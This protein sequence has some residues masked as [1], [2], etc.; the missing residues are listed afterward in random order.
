[1]L[2][3]HLRPAG[4]QIVGLASALSLEC[5]TVYLGEG[6]LSYAVNATVV[7]TFPSGEQ[8]FEL[9]CRHIVGF[10]LPPEL[11]LGDEELAAYGQVTT[12]PLVLP[13]LRS[14][15]SDLT[16]RAGLPPLVLDTV[17]IPLPGRPTPLEPLEQ[18][19]TQPPALA[20]APS[21]ADIGEGSV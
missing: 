17:R 19:T 20:E 3:W 15:V 6:S 13:Y 7:A 4:A 14:L 5:E 12:I 18:G 10:A 11:E 1:V 9:S 8:L 2:S 21:S 16:A